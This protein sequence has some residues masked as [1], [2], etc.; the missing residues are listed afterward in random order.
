MFAV[1]VL[2]YGLFVGTETVQGQM[3]ELRG[4]LPEEAVEALYNQ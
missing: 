3:Q 4:I 2:V 1:L